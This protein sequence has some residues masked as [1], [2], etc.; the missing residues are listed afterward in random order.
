M[1][2]GALP[3][4]N[5]P[6]QGENRSK[7]DSLHQ[8][9]AE[10]I[11]IKR[12]INEEEDRGKRQL[13]NL[14][15]LKE[16]VAEQR[17]R[18]EKEVLALEKNASLVDEERKAMMKERA[19]LDSSRSRSIAQLRVLESQIQSLKVMIPEP[20]KGELAVPLLKLERPF[21]EEDWLDRYQ[22]AMEILQRTHAFHRRYSVVQHDVSPERGRIMAGTILYM[23][24]SNAYFLSVDGSQA[25][26]GRPGQQGWVW[27]RSDEHLQDI[28]EA[29][30]MAEGKTIDF[31]LAQLPVEVQP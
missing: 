29:I 15:Q 22:A 9:T 4:P 17:G 11:Q 10:W 3:D 20:L 27:Q 5:P 24:L 12:L 2:Q 18:W 8:V 7:L 14:R 13:A 16:V 23:G 30:A 1:V 28:K 31:K 25:A 21:R 6:V 19:D 26:W